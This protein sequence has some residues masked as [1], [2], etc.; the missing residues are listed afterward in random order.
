MLTETLSV[1]QLWPGA[2]EPLGHKRTFV[3]WGRC[4]EGANHIPSLP[5]SNVIIQWVTALPTGRRE[6]RQKIPLRPN[7]SQGPPRPPP[8]EARGL[9][10]GPQRL[11]QKLMQF[12]T[13]QGSISG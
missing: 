1:T 3:P 10:L 5:F 7:S 13:A 9:H 8:Q 2:S 12:L 4:P 6:R 11:E